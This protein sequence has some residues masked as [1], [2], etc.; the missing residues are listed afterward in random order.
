MRCLDFQLL[1]SLPEA[2]EREL[3]ETLIGGRGVR[4]E[5]IISF[6][7]ASPED[8]WYDQDEAEWVM[9]LSGRSRVEIEGEAE[10]RDLG[11]GDA[12]FLPAHCRYRVSWTSPDE[13]TVWLAVFMDGSMPTTV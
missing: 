11:P 7:H 8:F 1:S 12:V 2:S 4:I 13:P 10:A 3:T 9:V 5:R 6:G